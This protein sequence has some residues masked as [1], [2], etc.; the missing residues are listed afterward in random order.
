MGFIACRP[1]STAHNAGVTVLPIDVRFSTWESTLELAEGRLAIRMGFR[2]IKG[3]GS[4][5]KSKLD[6]PP[7]PESD[8]ALGAFARRL[9]LA[10][11]ALEALAEAGAFHM[12][13]SRRDVL[14][15]IM[16]PG[17]VRHEPLMLAEHNASSS[18]AYL[19]ELERIVWDQRRTAH[20][21]RGAP[22]PASASLRPK[23][24]M[25]LVSTHTLP[26]SKPRQLCRFSNLSP[27]PEHRLRVTFVTLEDEDGFV[28]LVIWKRSPSAFRSRSRALPCSLRRGRSARTGDHSP[29]R[30]PPLDPRTRRRDRAR[31]EP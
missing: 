31:C 2:S 24:V 5:Q 27:A 11:P 9:Q 20:S 13:G 1:S 14:W 19:S 17:L 21:T 15:Q 30:A 12:F 29:D 22:C 26:P 10:R 8:E 6:P 28:N 7:R 3:L 18:F 25:S 16:E 23:G 4:Q